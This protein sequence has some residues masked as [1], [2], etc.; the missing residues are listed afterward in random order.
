MRKTYKSDGVNPSVEIGD[1]LTRNLYARM[2]PFDFDGSILG[3]EY[4]K[5]DKTELRLILQ[6][7][8]YVK[9]EYLQKDDKQTGDLFKENDENGNPKYWLN[10]RAQCDLVR[11]SNPDV[12]CL[13]GAMIDISLINSDTGPKFQ[14]GQFIER[15][16]NVI[17]AFIDNG[18]IVEF[19]LH[20]LE[21]FRWK[22]K[23]EN[24]VGRILPPYINKIQQ[25]YATYLGRQGLSRIPEDVIRR[26]S[27]N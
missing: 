19:L 5:I 16:D 18:V 15:V 10:I 27:L 17:I 24:R 11:H 13:K 8:R 26:T 23:Q 12:Y 2:S 14:N 21:K 22:D 3:K 4:S 6:G 20:D 7:E 1:L 25:K 9:Q